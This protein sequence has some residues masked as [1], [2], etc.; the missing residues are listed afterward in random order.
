MY[1]KG[2]VTRALLIAAT[3]A[4]EYAKGNHRAEHGVG[5]RN[6]EDNPI[7]RNERMGI[8]LFHAGL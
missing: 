5:S 8:M 1:L 2:Y 6:S 4:P 3:G 7:A